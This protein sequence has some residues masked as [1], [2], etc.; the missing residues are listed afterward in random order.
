MTMHVEF[1]VEEESAEAFLTE[2]V[3]KITEDM[4]SFRV[5]RFRGKHELLKKLPPRLKGTLI[6]IALTAF[7]FFEMR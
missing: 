5:I 1:L 3:P 7:K 6:I 2:M 4:I